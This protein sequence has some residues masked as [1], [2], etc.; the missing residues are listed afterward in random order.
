MVASCSTS[1]AARSTVAAGRSGSNGPLRQLR[2]PAFP[3]PSPAGVLPGPWLIL[4][5]GDGLRIKVAVTSV[6]CDGP[7][8]TVHVEPS[9]DRIQPDGW[10]N[11]FKTGFRRDD[12]PPF[13][14][15][16]N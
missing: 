4:G 6:T 3:G 7:P 11:S 13:L 5:P 16:T 15:V 1:A 9:R 8:P 14:P 10:Q 2:P 12:P